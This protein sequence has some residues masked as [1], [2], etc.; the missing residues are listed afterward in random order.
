[1]GNVLQSKERPGASRVPS[2]SAVGGNTLLPAAT[3][4]SNGYYVV[5]FPLNFTE[6]PNGYVLYQLQPNGVCND[7]NYP[8][9]QGDFTNTFVTLNAS[10]PG[11]YSA[12]EFVSSTNSVVNDYH[13]FGLLPN[14]V[15]SVPVGTAFIH[16]TSYAECSFTYWT[17]TAKST[18][19]QD[20]GINTYSGTDVVSASQQSWNS[21]GGWGDNNALNLRTPFTGF[22]NETTSQATFT[23][24][25]PVSPI[26]G[27]DANPVNSSDG[28]T[29]I[30][31]PPGQ[32]LPAG[33]QEALPNSGQTKSNPLSEGTYTQGTYES[34]S[35][36]TDWLSMS[37]GWEGYTVST[38]VSILATTTISSSIG[39]TAACSFAYPGVDPNGGSPYFYYH[40]SEPT[41]SS[42]P[43]PII[44]VWFVGYCNGRGGEPTC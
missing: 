5:S 28:V 24:L 43:A 11:F 9:G 8:G 7:E 30:T 25:G 18:V 23:S 22:V 3:A 2:T 21:P 19:T 31:T 20:I 39:S 4:D 14:V 16:G 38:Q 13:E 44:D 37:V 10:S 26:Q 17:E 42:V 36:I 29:L 41:D 12:S 15:H 6:E 35:G 40:T 34:T 32:Q 27:P 1:M 33:W